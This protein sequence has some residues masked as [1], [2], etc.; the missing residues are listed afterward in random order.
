MT[1]ALLHDRRRPA[2]LRRIVAYELL[3][4]RALR[5][6]AASACRQGWRKLVSRVIT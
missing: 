4:L 2:L 5:G 6:N 1:S 3:E